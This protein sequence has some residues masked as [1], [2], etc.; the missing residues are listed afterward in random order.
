MNYKLSLEVEKRSSLPLGYTRSRKVLRHLYLQV[1]EVKYLEVSY[2]TISYK[3]VITHHSYVCVY[4]LCKK[5][6]IV[7]V[8][9]FGSVTNLPSNNRHRNVRIV[10]NSI[11]QEP[12]L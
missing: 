1:I 10:N 4:F 2:H 7:T 11:T 12:T 3:K 8:V 5:A 9:L 6:M